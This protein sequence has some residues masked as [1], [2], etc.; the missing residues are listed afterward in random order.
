MN[1]DEALWNDLHR[2]N[3]E[4]DRHML[5]EE[6]QPEQDPDEAYEREREERYEQQ[7]ENQ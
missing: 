5:E 3:S 6:D 7:K 4:Y 2:Y 1:F